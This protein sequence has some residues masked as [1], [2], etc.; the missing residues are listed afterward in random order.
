MKASATPAGL[1][2]IFDPFVQGSPVSVMARGTVERFLSPEFLDKWF[3]ANAVGQYTLKV[4][5][6][7]LV[8]LIANVVIGSRK[9]VRA[10]FRAT[11]ELMGGS[12]VAVYQKLQKINP[13]TSAALVRY[14]SGEAAATIRKFHGEPQPLLAGYHAKVIDGSHIASSER[15]IKELRGLKAGPLPGQSLVVLDPVLRLPLDVFPCEDGHTQ[16][17][18]LLPDVLATVEAKDVWIADRNFCTR[19]FLAGIAAK[20]G[21]FIIRQHRNLPTRDL[22]ELQPAGEGPTG[23]IF[24]QQVA[25][26]QEDGTEK[27]YRRILVQVDKKTRDGDDHIA[28]LTNLPQEVDAPRIGSL[29]KGRWAIET[30]FQELEAHL[31]SEIATL[32]YPKA[33]LFGFCVALVCYIVMAVLKG[34][35]EAVHGPG[36]ILNLSNYFLADEIEGT[37]RGMMFAVPDRHWKVFR[38]LTQAQFA[39]LILELAR[40]VDMR[41]FQKAP[42]R[43]RKKPPERLDQ[44]ASSHVSTARILALRRQQ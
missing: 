6:S 7:T 43:P 39:L 41:R 29:Y 3:E 14:A 20:D 35:L 2:A 5:F 25:V 32:G 40:A 10:G 12:L 8:H 36:T 19:D 17:R 16:E 11:P 42:T 37:E 34:A 9:S 26:P 30:V 18:A 24:E 22:T 15:R 4:F 13:A 31:R 44:P 21:F 1:P 33:A 27:I 23:K 28:I 38:K